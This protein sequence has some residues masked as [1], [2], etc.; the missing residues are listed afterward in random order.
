MIQYQRFM[1][2][3]FF[4]LDSVIEE[5]TSRFEDFSSFCY[6]TQKN[7]LFLQKKQKRNYI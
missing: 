2:I 1:K 7:Q 6:W 5:L 4:K 3:D